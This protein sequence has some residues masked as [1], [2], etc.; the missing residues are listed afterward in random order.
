VKPAR[1]VFQNVVDLGLRDVGA[2]NE[3][4]RFKRLCAQAMGSL[5]F[6]G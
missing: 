2:R 6:A 4:R 1:P 5:R 3:P